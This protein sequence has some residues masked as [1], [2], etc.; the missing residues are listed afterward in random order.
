MTDDGQDG[1]PGP[2]AAPPPP[3]RAKGKAGVARQVARFRK[4]ARG[5][6]PRLCPLCG[7][8]GL[9]QA[10]GH[11]PRFDARCPSCH[12]FKLWM[13][14]AE[15]FQAHHAVLHF[16][17]ERQLAPQIRA[18]VGRYETAD[19]SPRRPVTHHVDIAATGLP[20]A[21]F[22]RIVCNHVLEHVDDAAALREMWRLLRPG[23][24]LVLST[25]IVEGWA[26]TYEN[27]AVT[28]PEDR[29]LHFGQADHRRIY[30]RDLRDRIRA[31]GFALSEVTAEEPDVRIHGLQ[32]GETL[33]LATKA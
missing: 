19:L 7:F 6:A 26:R 11:P 3:T 13:T 17:P 15:P 18:C 9:F 32:R 16:A 30:G 29:V 28:T 5:V 20:E 31:A 33:F 27:P 21:S 24:L 22:D 8:R 23:G 1:P 10:F 4:A 2:A 12:A 14:R 25:P